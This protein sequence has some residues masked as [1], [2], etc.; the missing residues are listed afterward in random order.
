MHWL[1]F[2]GSTVA[3]AQ[4]VERIVARGTQSCLNVRN[5]RNPRRA[6]HARNARNARNIRKDAK[7][8]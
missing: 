7:H 5:A 8:E 1:R 3:L 6:R 2:F 4:V